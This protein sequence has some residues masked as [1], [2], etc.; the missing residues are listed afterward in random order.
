MV[1][2]EG[3]KQMAGR[4]TPCNVLEETGAQNAEPR[5]ARS[6]KGSLDL[7][8]PPRDWG[9]AGFR[10]PWEKLLPCA[11][12]PCSG[13]VL[14][15]VHLI[16]LLVYLD[17]V[18]GQAHATA[19]YNVWALQ[20]SDAAGNL[21]SVV[22]LCCGRLACGGDRAG[23]QRR[24]GWEGLREAA[25]APRALLHGAKAALRLRLRSSL[26]LAAKHA[27]VPSA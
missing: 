22:Y 7:V 24:W 8:G 17:D 27:K 13:N 14:I 5:L 21:A 3:F 15:M 11:C 4:V 6:A 10:G 18:R 16:A 26:W 2:P 20:V 25:E 12:T 19:T 1:V 23:T 9:A